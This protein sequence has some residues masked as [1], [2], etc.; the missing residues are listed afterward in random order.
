MA[1]RN[2]RKKINKGQSKNLKKQEEE[3]NF[4]SKNLKKR[5]EDANKYCSI[6][7]IST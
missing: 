7:K 6:N 4:K 2:Q 3:I 1:F 5:K